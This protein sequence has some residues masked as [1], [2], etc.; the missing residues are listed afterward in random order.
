MTIANCKV[1][2]ILVDNDSLAD[3][4]FLEAYQK[5]G[6]SKE[7]LK[8]VEKLLQGFSGA[9]VKVEGSIELPVRVGTRDSKASLMINFLVV[10]ITSAYNT[11]LRRVSLNLLKAVV[12]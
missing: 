4:L 6:L 11:I 8:K 10:D 2:R 1:K 3:I 7:K 5:I 12:S 9:S